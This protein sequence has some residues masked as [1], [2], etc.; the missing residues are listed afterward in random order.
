MYYSVSRIVFPPLKFMNVEQNVSFIHVL[1]RTLDNNFTHSENKMKKYIQKH[2]QHENRKPFSCSCISTRTP[3]YKRMVMLFALFI[4]T[5]QFSLL[6]QFNLHSYIVPY[7]YDKVKI[8]ALVNRNFFILIFVRNSVHPYIL[9]QF[10][11]L[12]F[13]RGILI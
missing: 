2:Y 12:I 11:P 10:I 9:M 5:T 13:W 6:V 3:V 7:C 8:I 4:C 1:I